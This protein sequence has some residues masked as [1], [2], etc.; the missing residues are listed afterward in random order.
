MAAMAITIDASILTAYYQA[1]S[2]AAL[3]ATGGGGAGGKP[4]TPTPPWSLDSTA[5][6]ASALVKSVLAGARFVNPGAAKL[7]VPTAPSDYK[8]L[9]ALYQG[10]NALQG[11]ADQASAK[12]I[13]E[14]EK[15]RIRT[16][17]AEGLAEVG[18]YID[19]ADFDLFNLTQGQASAKLVSTAGA[20]ATND[21]YLTSTLWTGPSTG[22]PPAFQGNVAFS[23]S[24][25]EGA[26][27]TQVDFDLSEM[28]ATPR[29][30]SNVVIYL[31]DKLTAAGLSTRFAN[32]R[33][34][35]GDK[36]VMVGGKA[37]VIG[38]EPD[39]YALK[40]KGDVGE[41]LTFSAPASAPAVYLAGSSGRDT[42]KADRRSSSPSSRPAAPTWPAWA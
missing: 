8:K 33:I 41:V 12:G 31:N 13:S 30:M 14:A 17:F 6:R 42:D 37:T 25:Q 39:S 36:T 29:T 22:L 3:A 28:G 4:K 5:P 9:F 1:K 19:T 2:G 10:L 18:A 32:E 35:G 15:T 40:I 11:L 26:V 7:D 38:T 20:R 23:V 16:R 27:A 21:T 34:P 24:V